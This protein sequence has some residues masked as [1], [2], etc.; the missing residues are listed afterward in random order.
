MI[1][2]RWCRGLASAAAVLLLAAAPLHATTLHT[3]GFIKNPADVFTLHRDGITHDIRP[4]GVGGFEGTW[5]GEDIL[6]WCFD[7]DQVFNFNHNYTDYSASPL[8][9]PQLEDVQ[10]LFSIG[11]AQAI[12]DPHLSAA[13]QLALWN[14]EYDT[15]LQVG[16]GSFRV[17]SG[18][19]G[20]AGA[21]TQA[22]TWLSELHDANGAGWTITRLTST[23]HQDF[24]MG[25]RTARD[26]PEPPTT[27][28]MLAA[29]IM[30]T[31]LGAGRRRMVGRR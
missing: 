18:S 14:I 22:N 21:V 15:D 7:L 24:V 3:D 10:R 30:A 12:T 8:T 13:F 6:F 19:S 25:V 29:L 2:P 27:A 9:A 4:L 31:A 16:T 23:S 28:L 1:R 17:Y 20:S 26:V 11:Y 5:G